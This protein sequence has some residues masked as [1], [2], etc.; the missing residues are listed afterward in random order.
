MAA[1]GIG[2]QDS[3]LAQQEPSRHDHLLSDTAQNHAEK[4]GRRIGA[5]LDWA[6]TPAPRLRALVGTAA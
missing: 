6:G 4:F 2:S 3:Q 5:F 1:F